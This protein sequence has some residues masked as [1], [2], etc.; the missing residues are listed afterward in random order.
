MKNE[1]YRKWT[2]NIKKR[3][4]RSLYAKVEKGGKKPMQPSKTL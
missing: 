1:S 4:H 2:E 3:I